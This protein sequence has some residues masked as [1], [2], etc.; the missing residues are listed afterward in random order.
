[1]PVGQITAVPVGQRTLAPVSAFFRAEDRG[2][3]TDF[4]RSSVAVSSMGALLVGVS[5]RNRQQ[6]NQYGSNNHAIQSVNAQL[7]SD[8]LARSPETM[9]GPSARGTDEHRPTASA[10]PPQLGENRRHAPRSSLVSRFAPRKL[11]P[12]RHNLATILGGG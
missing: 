7:T 4:L 8:R 5:I 6:R 9:R 2:S 11:W 12:N 10:A 3:L 1:V